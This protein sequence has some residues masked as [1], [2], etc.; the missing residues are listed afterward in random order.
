[1]SDE[2]SSGQQTAENSDYVT[3]GQESI[4]VVKDDAPVDDPIDEAEADSDKQLEQDDAEAVNESNILDERTR[5]A[6]PEAGSYKEPSDSVPGL[7]E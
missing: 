7:E 1:M 3:K 2:R 5:G 4:P 6:K